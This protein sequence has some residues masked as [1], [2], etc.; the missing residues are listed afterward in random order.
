MK[1]A[2]LALLA[3]TLPL[4]AQAAPFSTDAARYALPEGQMVGHVDFERLRE[5]KTFKDLYA[6]LSGNP[7]AQQG[8]ADLE[9][10]FGIKLLSDL[11]SITFSVNAPKAG[12]P[13]ETLVF[14]SGLFDELKIMAGMKARGADYDVKAEGAQQLYV[15]Q[16]D[17]TA[18]AFVKGGLIAANSQVGG[19]EA[20]E[21]ESSLRKAL[22]GVGLGGALKGLS[23]QFTTGKDVWFAL[24]PNADMLADLKVQDAQMAA[25][26]AWT[27][28]IDL[29]A[30]LH[31]HAEGVG[32]PE[33]AGAVAGKMMAQVQGA[34][35]SPQAAMLG[36]MITK[37]SAKAEGDRLVVDLPLSQQ[38][39]DQ[40]KMLG[41]MALAAMQSASRPEPKPSFPAL[42]APAAPAAP[43]APEPVKI[44]PA[45]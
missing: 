7:G 8:I 32:T 34:M 10:R 39:V 25:F 41:M 12:G 20:V 6:M 37:F 43:T 22:K 35:A 44:L 13:T 15:A 9:S 29:S 18:L 5:S 33:A 1:K 38:D 17:K 42:K 4:S 28:S 24:A 45:P 23:A 11:G 3:L 30:G 27:L 2:L 14:A 36:G 16:G 19:P 21:G 31:V 40:L 26:T